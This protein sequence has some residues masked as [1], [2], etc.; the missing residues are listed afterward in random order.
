M[1]ASYSLSILIILLIA[2][3]G[4]A[5]EVARP[6]HYQGVYNG[7]GERH[8]SGTYVWENG[9]TYTGQW[10]KNKMSGEGTL[11]FADSSSYKGSFEKGLFHGYG[12]Y[13]WPNG[14]WYK[15]W[16]SQG[17][18]SGNGK[19][20][21]ENGMSYQG[22]WA[23]DNING[24][25]KMRYPN[26]SEYHGEWRD[27]LPHGNGIMLYADGKMSQGT[28]EKGNYIP[29]DCTY[30]NLSAIDA[31]EQADAVFIGEVLAVG[32]LDDYDIVTFEVLSYWKGKLFP[33]RRI[34]LKVNYT[35]CD[36]IFFEN[37][38]YLVYAQHAQESLYKTSKCSRTVAFAQVRY[39]IGFL[40]A[41]ITCQEERA[42]PQTFLTETDYVC[43]CDGKTY[44]NP[45]QAKIKGIQR[46]KAG[47]CVEN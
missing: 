27:N 5:Q 40:N 28:F 16:F 6:T 9:S 12:E 43:G 7:L 13:I 10:R 26:G 30:T 19:F 44:K 24:I 15:G 11:A 23:K 37:Q 25:G 14:N 36:N 42:Q 22:S 1:P 4:Y 39:D 47:A 20:S 29:C 2:S 32:S 38:Q 41:H 17:K 21:L 3:T 45:Y 18:K 46:W 8:G 34:F 31:F 33:N 35:S